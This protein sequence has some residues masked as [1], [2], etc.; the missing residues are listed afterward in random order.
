MHTETNRDTDIGGRNVLLSDHFYYFGAIPVDLPTFLLQIVLQGQGHKSTSN[1]KY[2]E[3]FVK[4]IET[5]VE[6]GSNFN[7]YNRIFR[8]RNI[9]P[10]IAINEIAKCKLVDKDSGE[11][12]SKSFFGANWLHKF[13]LT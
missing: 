12:F 1:E 4:W 6:N 8:L 11:L 9:E 2:A 10:N 7:T 5:F 3:K 13:Q